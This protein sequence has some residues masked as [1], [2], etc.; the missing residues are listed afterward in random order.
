M[1]AVLFVACIW[2][3]AYHRPQLT[4]SLFLV[5]AFLVFYTAVS[6]SLF[7]Q[8]VLWGG[9][10]ALS[11]VLLFPS[12]RRRLISDR[13]F[14]ILKQAMPS[15]SQT[16]KDALEA[17]SV[18]WDG[19]L[20][21]GKPDWRKLHSFPQPVLSEEER[22]FVE[23]PV[24]VLCNMVDDWKV[25]HEDFDLSPQVWKY[26][27]DSGF[28]GMIIPKEY[29]GKGFSALAH[30]T[31]VTKVSTRSVTA[32]VTVM[33]PNSL[34][35][36][37]LLLR[38]GTE[39]QKSYYLPRL[40]KGQEIPCFALTGPDAG[41]DAGAMPDKGIV[42]KGEFEGQQDVLGIRVTWEK[43]YITLGPVATVLGLAFKLYDPNHLIGDT[44]N[45]GITLALIPTKTP[46]VNIGRRHMPLN[47]AFQNGPNS[48][49]DVFIPIDWIIG[50]V[51]KAGH[52][53][54]MLMDCLAA[55]R[56]ISL[57]ALSTGGGKIASRATASYAHVRKQFKIPIGRFEGVEEVLARI[58]G[59]AYLMDSARIMTAG[60]VDQG[61]Q[62]SVVSAIVKYHLT[63]RMRLVINDAMDIHGGHGICLGP[64][65]LLGRFYQSIPVAITVE[66]ANILTRSMIIF[67][68]GA[69]RCH[70]Y[71]LREMLAVNNP[72]QNK[73]RTD[74][75]HAIFGHIGFAIS[76]ALRSLFMGLTGS[77]L[78]I[79]PKSRARVYYQR[80]TRMSSAFAFISDISML[81]LGG[82]LKRKEKLSGRLADTLSQLYLG[83]AVLKHYYDQGEHSPDFHFARWACED[84]LFKAQE[85]LWGVVRNFPI[86]PVA[87]FMRF[88]AFPFGRTYLPPSDAL[89]K[90]IASLI[91]QPGAARDR[92]TEHVFIPESKTQ[93]VALLDE[94]LNKVIAA[95]LAEKKL[96]SAVHSGLCKAESHDELLQEALEKEVIDANEVELIRAAVDIRREVIQVDD[97]S[98]QYLS[99]KLATEN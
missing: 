92:L 58:A 14:P 40:A 13:I 61:E 54:R 89:G 1:W 24:E 6:A 87:W 38:Y 22:A 10:I 3:I 30:S 2:T 23:G 15:M 81:V 99:Q 41:S 42:C 19:D 94:A 5:A 16:E 48:G 43:R 76:N 60:A 44:E 39:K 11:A 31:V 7:T 26:L 17:G 21:S 73:G 45:I 57:P 90:R 62:P 32:A 20:F 28:F 18:W 69:I 77:R 4:L 50:G 91:L 52:G 80:F 36:A 82:A 78:V 53:W 9:F 95:E 74:F 33:V 25:T 86:R 83:S 66:G 98:S 56:S 84:T 72:D 59:N 70:P 65:N 55:G 88:V 35:P 49:T 63:E 67:G 96:N 37:E 71:V 51:E 12:L 93:I 85:A 34:G 68:Q 46:G 47:S 27:K 75:D 29:G 8:I 97:F 79:T 64:R